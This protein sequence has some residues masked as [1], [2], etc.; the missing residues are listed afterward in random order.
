MNLYWIGGRMELATKDTKIGARL[1]SEPMTITREM[2]KSFSEPMTNYFA[3]LIHTD[4][5][6]AKAS[7]FPTIVV[8]GLQVYGIVSE[9]LAGYFREGWFKGGKLSIN[10]LSPIFPNDVVTAKGIVKEKI[11]EKDSIRLN[12][13]VW[14]EN[15]W[16]GKIIMGN[17]SGLVL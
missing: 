11:I 8:E 3:F 13:R 4:D 14:V 16:R 2:A 9:M 15:Q 10:F 1:S 17:A 7:G 12:L 6:V 5:N